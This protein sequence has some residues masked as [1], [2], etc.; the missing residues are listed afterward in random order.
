MDNCWGFRDESDINGIYKEMVKENKCIN[1]KI[2]T[3]N[4]G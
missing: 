4:T 2:Q 1:V 3:G